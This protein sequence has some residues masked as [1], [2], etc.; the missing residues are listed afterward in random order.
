[1][2]KRLFKGLLWAIVLTLVLVL[3]FA[4]IIRQSN[5]DD[6]L[7]KPIV[8]GIKVLCILIGVGIAIKNTTG[9]GWL[10]GGIMGVL[11]TVF[12]FCI[13]S[14]IDGSFVVDL[15]ALNDLVFAIIIGIISAM[16]FRGRIKEIDA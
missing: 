6:A 13:F 8:Q 5:L 14:A 11:Y 12:A 1:M 4:F 16:L 15:S 3:A 7:I 2:L 10:W 9:H